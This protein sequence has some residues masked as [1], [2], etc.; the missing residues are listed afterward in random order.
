MK[1][2]CDKRYLKRHEKGKPTY[3]ETHVRA[4]LNRLERQ[5]GKLDDSDGGKHN[6]TIHFACGYYQAIHDVLERIQQAKR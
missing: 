5:V 1:E 4:E 2:R 3:G 6:Q